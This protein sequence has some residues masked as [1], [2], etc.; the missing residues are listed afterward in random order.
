[1]KGVVAIDTCVIIH[2]MYINRLHLLRL[3]EYSVITTVYVQLEFEQGHFDSLCYYKKLVDS[4]EINCK[5][6][7]GNRRFG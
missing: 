4:G 6:P 7:F 2:F 5:I 1:M 3:L